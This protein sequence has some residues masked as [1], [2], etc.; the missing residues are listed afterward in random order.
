MELIRDLER[1]KIII[2][3]DGKMVL[4]LGFFADEFTITTYTDS[5]IVIARET[6]D[7]LYDELTR[8]MENNYTFGNPFSEKTP[9]KIVWFSDQAC[10]IENKSETDKVTRLV[11]EREGNCFKI[12]TFNPFFQKLGFRRNSNVVAL[13]PLGNGFYAKN[14][15][16]GYNF[17]DEVVMAF[18]RTLNRDK[19][20]ELNSGKPFIIR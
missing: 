3:N 12:S 15:D 16:T 20:L 17:Q 6:D 13:S 7:F 19:S 2:Y 5:N 11:I 14:T 10:D 4:E 1:K 18:K 8:L 9:D